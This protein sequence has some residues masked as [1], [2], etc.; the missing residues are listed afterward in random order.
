MAIRLKKKQ[1]TGAKGEKKK[2]G[3]KFEGRTVKLTIYVTE[4]VAKDFRE[5]VAERSSCDSRLGSKIIEDWL[6]GE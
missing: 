1:K 2:A 4:K 5:E 6:Y 3:R